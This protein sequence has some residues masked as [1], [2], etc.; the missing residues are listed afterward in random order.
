MDMRWA[1]PLALLLVPAGAA[2]GE[3]HRSAVISA[4]GRIGAL[5]MDR[6][7]RGDVIRFAGRPD[8]ERRGVEYDSTPYLAIGYVCSAEANDDAFPVLKTLATSRKRPYCK[9]VFWINLLT[10]RLGD[11]FTAS[12][13]FSES[14]G[15]RIGC[16]RKRNVSCTS[17][18]TWG[19][20]RTW[21]L[22]R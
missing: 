6:S 15:V 3:G 12:A 17:S 9:T 18:S 11:F 14:R 2:C 13:R 10:G 16:G 8:V 20:R 4:D 19:A 22:G 1:L 5:R 21:T 7:D